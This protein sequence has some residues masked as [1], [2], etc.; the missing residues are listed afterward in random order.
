M[1][2]LP[3]WCLRRSACQVLGRSPI[4]V[5]VCPPRPTRPQGSWASWYRP[6]LDGRPR[7]LVRPLETDAQV[8]GLVMA[9]GPDVDPRDCM[10]I[11]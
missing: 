4:R 11:H 5:D 3:W 8:E 9:R 7:G 6:G 10:G 1:P 2:H